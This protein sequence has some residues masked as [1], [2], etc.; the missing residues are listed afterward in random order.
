MSANLASNGVAVGV[1]DEMTDAAVGVSYAH[2]ELHAGSS[3]V[4]SVVNQLM[5]DTETLSLAF[6][7]P[8]GTKHAHLFAHFSTLVGGKLEIV[9]APTWTAQTGTEV[10]I[11]NRKRVGTPNSSVLLANQAQAGFVA[12]DVVVK[13]MA[14]VAG[15]TIL[16]ANYA[17]G[18]RSRIGA[19]ETRAN[20]EYILK[21]DTQYL[22][23]FTAIGANNMAQLVLDWYEH[24]DRS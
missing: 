19:G 24:T 15:G 23:L 6:K 20:S 14:G 16:P 22:I 9:E 1:V 10:P 3:F 12:A 8:A 11:V 21:P 13:D 4:A 17:F 7:T 5:A 18:Q 2:H